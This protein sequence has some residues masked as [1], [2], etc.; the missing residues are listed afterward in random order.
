MKFPYTVP[1]MIPVADS[2]WVVLKIQENL[3]ALDPKTTPKEELDDA[4][5][6]VILH[7]VPFVANGAGFIDSDRAGCLAWNKRTGQ[8]ARIT[9]EGYDC[10]RVIVSG[11]RVIYTG[12]NWRDVRPKTSE[13]VCY[14]LDTQTSRVLVPQGRCGSA[15]SPRKTTL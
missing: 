2:D 7:E 11:R 15:Q 13:L 5:D 9:P 12:K 14:D 6:Y 3:H 10:G 4:Q 8:Q 1:Q